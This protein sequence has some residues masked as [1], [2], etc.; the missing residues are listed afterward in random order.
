M[1]KSMGAEHNTYISF[2]VSPQK[3]LI[4]YQ[5]GKVFTMD[6]SCEH[7]LNHMIKLSISN[8]GTNWKSVPLDMIYGKGYNT[9]YIVFLLHVFNILNNEKK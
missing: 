6:K 2:E 1:L 4:N 8:N 5:G 3:L 9:T 7:H